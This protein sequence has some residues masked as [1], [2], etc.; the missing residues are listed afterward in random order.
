MKNK[1]KYIKMIISNKLLSIIKRILKNK[2]FK[3]RI[4]KAICLK[5]KG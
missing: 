4:G 1:I 5:F 3:I 2:I